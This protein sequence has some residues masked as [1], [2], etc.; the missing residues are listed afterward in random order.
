MGRALFL[1]P[2]PWRYGSLCH[3]RSWLSEGIRV[4]RT[5]R[6]RSPRSQDLSDTGRSSPSAWT[7]ERSTTIWGWL[8][9]L[10]FAYA[11]VTRREAPNVVAVSL[12][13]VCRH[14]NDQFAT[15]TSVIA[16]ALTWRH[17]RVNSQ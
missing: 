13:A 3:K 17:S 12:V 1:A 4:L 9:Q 11:K 8:V 5:P 7:P 6:V 16:G 10:A 14:V 15:M 2:E